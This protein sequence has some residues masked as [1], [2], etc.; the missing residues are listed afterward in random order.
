MNPRTILILFSA[1]ALANGASKPIA[2][3]PDNPHY[4]LWRGKP[5]VL[6]TS[7][8]HYGAV[9]NPDFDYVKYLLTQ[10][11]ALYFKGGTNA[12]LT[13][14]LPKGNYRV[15]WVCELTGDIEQREELKHA[16]GVAVLAP[17]KYTSEIA[18]RIRAQ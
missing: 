13:L 9:L 7:G 6:V 3:H 15:E 18:L 14:D 16:G 2:L 4:F 12:N 8:E 10:N 1:V 17:K 11:I 5:T